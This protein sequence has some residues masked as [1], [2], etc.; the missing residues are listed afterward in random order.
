MN[1][2]YSS[3]EKYELEMKTYAIE[4]EN[5]VF[6]LGRFVMPIT[7]NKYKVTLLYFIKVKLL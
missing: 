1:R 4:V 3:R 2:R 5:P 6:P 7:E